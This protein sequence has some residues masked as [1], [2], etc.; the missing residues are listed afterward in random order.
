[1]N[2]SN[3]QRFLKETVSHKNL[4]I[5]FVLWYLLK[6]TE[7]HEINLSFSLSFFDIKEAIFRVVAAILHLGNIEFTKGQE[8][9]SSVPKDDK[10][11]FHLQTAAELFMY[12][13]LTSKFMVYILIWIFSCCGRWC[14]FEFRCDPFALEDALCKRVMITPEEVIKRSLDPGAATVSRDGLAKTVYSRLFDW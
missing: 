3:Y 11:K 1:M 2:R 14:H 13:C 4:C 7:I 6:N 9:D 8:I 5:F 10:A 12:I